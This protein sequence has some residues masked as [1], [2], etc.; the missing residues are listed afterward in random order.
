MKQVLL[1]GG[2]AVVEE[3]PA[4]LVEPGTLLVQV[5]HSCISVGTEMTGLSGSGTPLWRK[6]LKDPWKVKKALEMVATR[7]VKHTT[8]LVKGE[9]NAGAPTGYSAAGTVIAVG[10]GVEDFDVGDRVACAG[11]QCAHHAEIIRVPANL[12]VPV[13]EDLGFAA[14]STVTLGAIAMQGVRRGV[15]TLGETFVVV[16]LG[17]LGQLTVQLLKANGCRVIGCDLDASRIQA[18][19][20][21]GM[22]HALA[23][24]Q[25]IDVAR[26]AR[27]TDGIGADGV[28][29]T[30]A[31]PD[32]GLLAKAFQMC[33]RKG[34]VVLVGDV[35]M[36]IDRA[37]IYRN[38]ID[39]FISTSYGPGRY[40]QR[41]EEQGMDYPVAYV[42]WTEN[43]NMSEYLRLMADGRVQVDD[44]I[45][46][47]HP[48][49]DAPKAYAA[50]RHAQPRPLTVLLEYPTNQAVA[51]QHRVENPYAPPGKA[52]DGRVRLALIGA[53]AFAKG[54]HLPNIQGLS[55]D[56]A[57]HAV[58]SRTGANAKAVATQ[59]EARYATTDYQQV[60]ADDEV[61]A[62]L[63]AT[64]HH[65]HAEMTLA[66]LQAGKHVLVE[67][68]LLL[69]EAELAEIEAFFANT[70]SSPVL[71]TG[72]NR[73]FSPHAR[74]ITELVRNRTNPLIANYRMNAGHIPSDHWVHG[75]EGGGRNIGEACHIYDL[76]TALTN[77]EVTRIQ[78]HAIK[79]TTGHYRA[80]DNFIAQIGFADGSLAS[81]TY[82][83]LGAKEHPKERMEVYCDGRVLSL[84]DY[85]ATRIEGT[86][87]AEGTKSQLPDKGQRDELA[88]FAD[89]ALGRTDWPI[90]LWQQLQAMR[91]ALTVESALTSSGRLA[92]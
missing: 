33:R 90:P 23:P 15:P 8:S 84:D 48:V 17:I 35:P 52:N 31:S 9:L 47:I 37:D 58:V 56:L 16:G 61:D 82:T 44:L 77:A 54:M 49:T 73:R 5:S 57:L 89:A 40:D 27:L 24:D 45:G 87:K 11:A 38:E 81:L 22:D 30:A 72:F 13:P 62:V 32:T 36:Q 29:V 7:G 78:A 60:L 14:A 1:K 21:T 86:P 79:P 28:I 80:D 39:F 53:G 66:A 88:A 83:A 55:D 26:V 41:Y 4:P 51:S 43:R 18:A 42:R 50:L 74:R 76:F 3:V 64:R 67:K 71:L 46:E 20:K 92:S 65:L 85:R 59:Y 91:I 6:A 63:I 68:P 10:A 2:Q 19:E 25:D 70:K 34:R 12:S 75:P 69:T